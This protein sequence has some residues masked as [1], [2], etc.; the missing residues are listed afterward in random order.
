M[1]A[2]LGSTNPLVAVYCFLINICYSLNAISKTTV[3]NRLIC[4]FLKILKLGIVT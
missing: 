2:K 4:L 3:E 1:E